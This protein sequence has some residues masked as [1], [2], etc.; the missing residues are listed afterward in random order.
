M[1]RQ[2]PLMSAIEGAD[3]S[4]MGWKDVMA[5]RFAES[6]A[7]VAV[8]F[9]G[10]TRDFGRYVAYLPDLL[11]ASQC[12]TAAHIQHDIL[13]ARA[14]TPETLARYRL[15]ILPSVSCLSEAEGKALSDYV[16]NGGKLILTGPT[17]LLGE[18]GMPR[19]DFLLGDLANITLKKRFVKNVSL[20][21]AN[22]ALPVDLAFQVARKDDSQSDVLG[23][24]EN[25]NG[26]VVGPA[27]V[28]HGRWKGRG[29]L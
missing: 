26:D 7:D 16:R 28:A 29:G 25:R 6:M 13:F 8:V 18:T 22:R 24:L 9:S 12:L 19:D 1:N 4:Y 3:M 10:N 15:V 11:G 2:L 27:V 23:T 20:H 14:M 21:I 5:N 17:G